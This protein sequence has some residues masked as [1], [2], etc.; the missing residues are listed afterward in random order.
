MLL[1]FAGE[2]ENELKQVLGDTRAAFDISEH[3]TLVF[4]KL[5]SRLKTFFLHPMNL[6]YS[7]FTTFFFI[8][9][10]V[11]TEYWLLDQMHGTTNHCCVPTL[12]FKL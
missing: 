2:Y 1:C 10:Q 6:K 9:I 12:V 7:V 5:F 3:D 8:Y 11:L 4:G